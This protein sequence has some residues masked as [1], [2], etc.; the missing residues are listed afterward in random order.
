MPN[1]T[2]APSEDENVCSDGTVAKVC[3]GD[4]AVDELVALFGL[5]AFWCIVFII[6]GADGLVAIRTLQSNKE[7][8]ERL[9]SYLISVE[10]NRA[11]AL[12]R[13]ATLFGDQNR[14]NQE[15]IRALAEA[16][17]RD[18]E[19]AGMAALAAIDET[20]RVQGQKAL[21]EGSE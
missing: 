12:E 16:V 10:E 5:P 9:V 7:S 21:Q 3:L 8:T 1:T 4:M 15:V 18:S 6:V 13:Q 14:R 11:E 17:A 19:R 2:A 20:S